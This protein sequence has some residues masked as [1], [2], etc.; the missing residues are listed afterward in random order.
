M[1][2]PIDGESRLL[3]AEALAKLRGD[4]PRRFGREGRIGRWVAG[5]DLAGAAED[6]TDELV[7]ERLP[8]KDSTVALIGRVESNHVAV[9][10]VAWWTGRTHR[11]QRNRL[12]ALLREVWAVER[13][14][15]D[16][17]GLGAPLAEVL[18]GALGADVVEAVS[19]SASRKSELG[20]ALIEG[21]EAGRVRLYRPGPDDR[22]A[23]ELWHQVEAARA[24]VRPS[25][26]LRWEVP[27]WA[28][29]DDFVVALALLVR[30]AEGRGDGGAERTNGP[31]DPSA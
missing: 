26:L 27:A 17:S 7:R 2:E 29:H 12:V 14:A 13:V 3:S 31:D 10:D 22:E 5:I 25:C 23:T 6:R 24:Q 28:G 4:H 19:F 16:A 20:Y 11:E 15:V 1:S 8:R 30:A 18:A 21:A 9:E